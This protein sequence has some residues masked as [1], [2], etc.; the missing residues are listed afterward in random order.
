M[1]GNKQIVYIPLKYMIYI[2]RYLV[3]QDHKHKHKHEPVGICPDFLIEIPL[4]TKTMDPFSIFF[5]FYNIV[6]YDT[7]IDSEV[8]YSIGFSFS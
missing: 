2:T 3:P 1:S 8:P 4:K 6:K 7:C 5:I